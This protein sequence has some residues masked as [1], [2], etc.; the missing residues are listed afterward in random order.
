MSASFRNLEKEHK[1]TTFIHSRRAQVHCGGFPLFSIETVQLQVTHSAPKL[2]ADKLTFQRHRTHHH[3]GWF[4]FCW[5]LELIKVSK[6]GCFPLTHHLGGDLDPLWRHKGVSGA[7]ACHALHRRRGPAPARCDPQAGLRLVFAFRD[8][9]SPLPEGGGQLE[10]LLVG[11]SRDHLMAVC[12]F[13][14][15]LEREDQG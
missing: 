2:S 14:P 3:S 13:W 9:R 5:F 15:L 1:T 7:R 4:C 12:H 6:W 8:P 10:P 11:V